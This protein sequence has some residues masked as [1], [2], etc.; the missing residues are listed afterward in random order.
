VVV[1]IAETA[2]VTSHLPVIL[3]LEVHASPKQQQ[4]TADLFRQHFGKALVTNDVDM[5]V[6]LLEQLRGRFIL[7]GKTLA[8]YEAVCAS[9]Y[10]ES[11]SDQDQSFT[12]RVK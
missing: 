6:T 1:A 7:K 4:K 3:S 10:I 9:L 2:F 11:G 5:E 8:A 12:S